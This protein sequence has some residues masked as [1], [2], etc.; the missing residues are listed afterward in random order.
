MIVYQFPI[1]MKKPE[2]RLINM[3]SR[4]GKLE[5]ELLGLKT[6]LKKL[7]KERDRLLLPIERVIAFDLAQE[8]K[9]KEQ[10]DVK[11]KELMLDNQALQEILGVI[12]EKELAIAQK[13]IE[14]RQLERTFSTERLITKWGL[15]FQYSTIERMFGFED[16]AG[17]GNGLVLTNRSNGN[18]SG[19]DRM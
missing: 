1:E 18:G 15:A 4:L 8:C 12:E 13:E 17:T 19:S 9:N 2:T 3:P 7:F 16:D 10:R 5:Q 6:E 14:L 11:A